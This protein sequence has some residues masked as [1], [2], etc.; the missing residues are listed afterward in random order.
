MGGGCYEVKGR[1]RKD[2]DP[3]AMRA[4]FGERFSLGDVMEQDDM[5]RTHKEGWLKHVLE[6]AD[7]YD[8]PKLIDP[9]E[10]EESTPDLVPSDE[11]GAGIPGRVGSDDDG[12]AMPV[13]LESEVDGVLWWVR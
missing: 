9:N 2:I 11:D 1:K 12:G 3:L 5:E 10:Y 6:G 8:M 7:D 4:L 13:L